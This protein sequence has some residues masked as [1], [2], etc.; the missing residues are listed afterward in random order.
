MKLMLFLSFAAIA[1]AQP[2]KPDGVKPGEWSTLTFKESTRGSDADQLKMR[3]HAAETPKPFD[4]AK[5]TFDVF[6]PKSYQKGKPHGLIVWVSSSANVSVPKDWD[7]VLNDKKVIL[8]GARNSGNP[9]DV[10]DRMRMATDTNHNM[11][12]LYTID[13][14]RV[15]ISGM[16]GG[17]RVAS[18]LGVT[19]S[20]MFNGAICFMGV[21]FYEDITDDKE[22]YQARYY[23]ADVLLDVAKKHCRYA[24]VTGSKDFNLAN[25]T[26][27]FE[28]GFKKEGFT[29]VGLF[30]IPN[31]GHALPSGEWLAK[32]IDF[33]DDTK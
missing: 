23:P 32:C 5:E 29:G 25:T 30:N 1:A 3:L 28:Q 26:A 16:S 33:M 18:M 19:Y 4:I 12:Q 22:L 31:Q 15:W 21:N 14:K 27:L 24:L 9:R 7:K 6:V 17:S 2:A 10:F 20:D 13:T 11:R 8:V